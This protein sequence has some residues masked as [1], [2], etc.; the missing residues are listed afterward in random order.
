MKIDSPELYLSIAAMLL[1]ASALF[2]SAALAFR[3]FG[4]C[5]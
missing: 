5:S 2:L 1:S 4:V 3:T